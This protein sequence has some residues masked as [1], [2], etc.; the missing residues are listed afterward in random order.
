MSNI[1]VT[2]GGKYRNKYIEGS[3]EM[4][5]EGQN[6]GRSDGRVGRGTKVQF[7]NKPNTKWFKLLGTI[8]TIEQLLPGDPE[9]NIP[10][11]YKL[12]LNLLDVANQTVIKKSPTDRTTHQTILRSEGYSEDIIEQ[13]CWFPHG[14]Y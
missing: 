5:W 10:A 6:K 4:I 1:F 14:I 8:E 3:N 11:T 9:K 13:A 2:I 12:T 7:S